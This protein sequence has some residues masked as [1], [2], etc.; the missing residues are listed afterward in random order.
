MRMQGRTTVPGD[1]S[2]SHRALL[3]S[4]L[5]EGKSEIRGLNRGA[6][7][8]RTLT[9]LRN[10]GV[11]IASHGEVTVVQGRS[12]R[13]EKPQE[14]LTC[15][16]SGTTLRLLAGILAGQDFLSILD[17]DD[18][19][20]KRPMG[21]IVEPLRLMGA[22]VYG[23]GGS[24]FAPLSIRGGGL[25][26]IHYELPVPSAQVKSA[27]L[28]AG[29]QG[30]GT[31]TILEPIPTRDHTERMLHSCGARIAREG[32]Q[33]QIRGGSILHGQIYQVPGDFSSAAFL[34]GAAAALPGSELMLE[35]VGVNPTRLGFLDVL[36]AMGAQV[37]ILTVEERGGEPYGDLLV[38]GSR[39]TSTVV[40]G[41]IMARLVDEIPILAVL[42]TQAEGTT[43]IS[44]AAELRLKESDRLASLT[45]ELTKLGAQITE[46]PEGLEITG[47]TRLK[48][49]Q[50]HSHGD[51]RLALALEVA[52]LF[53]EGEVE[54]VGAEL[55]DISFPRFAKTLRGLVVG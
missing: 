50:V 19:L 22:D 43:V 39:L 13:L 8:I 52:S 3:I 26:G 15:G 1:K 32:N 41:E 17:G 27:L 28:L 44:D 37:E 54:V 34:I 45:E 46:H 30:T 48:G 9:C 29:L 49:A 51:H 53:A 4:A 18:S 35:G 11:E 24:N 6:D 12:L 55:G 25:W 21:R 10:L 36:E 7:C 38:R 47:P 20:R 14:M 2:I 33:I 40:G 42:A 16:N 31:T 23:T 5:A